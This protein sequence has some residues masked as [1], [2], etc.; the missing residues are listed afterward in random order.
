[1]NIY[2]YP[3]KNR[4]VKIYRK[5]R[6][7]WKNETAQGEYCVK[8]YIHSLKHPIN[9]YIRQVKADVKETENGDYPDNNY[10]I[11]INFREMPRGEYFVEWQGKTFKV[12]NIDGY[13][14]HKAELV[15]TCV[16]IDVDTTIYKRVEEETPR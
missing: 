8:H 5:K 13:E 1:M 4:Q 7:N 12:L 10:L 11:A 6:L 9:A 3:L 2:K 15:L 16:E 14:W